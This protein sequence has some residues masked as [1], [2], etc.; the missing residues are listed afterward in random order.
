[1]PSFRRIRHQLAKTRLRSPLTWLRH[2]S[3]DPADVF[4]G[5]YPRSGST[6]L[7]FV[8]LEILTGRPSEFPSVNR[9]IPKVGRHNQALPLLPGGGRLIQT[10]E[11]YREEYQKA[12]YLVR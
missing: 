11:P 4:I 10:H 2:R 7:R 3:F 6:W 8:L 12:V 9:S 5:S 1:M